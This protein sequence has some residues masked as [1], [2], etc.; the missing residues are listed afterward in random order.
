[1]ATRISRTTISGED[2]GC[3]EF[4]IGDV[5]QYGDDWAFVVLGSG[6]ESIESFVTAAGE[7]PNGRA[8]PCSRFWVSL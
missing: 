7:L 5:E 8:R 1:L 4:W 2:S 3:A 6:T